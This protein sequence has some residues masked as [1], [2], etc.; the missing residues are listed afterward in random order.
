MVYHTSVLV[1]PHVLLL[2][3]CLHELRQMV[4]GAADKETVQGSAYTSHHTRALPVY[5]KGS[6]NMVVMI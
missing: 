3:P 1:H 2:L 6:L 5:G 4:M